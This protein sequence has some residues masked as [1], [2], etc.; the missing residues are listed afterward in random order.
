MAVMFIVFSVHFLF[1]MSAVV[2]TQVVLKDVRQTD[3]EDIK[4]AIVFGMRLDENEANLMYQM[5]DINLNK[6]SDMNSADL[7][8]M[9]CTQ[10]QFIE[11]ELLLKI[12]KK[13]KLMMMSLEEFLS[14]EA[15]INA[16]FEY[17]EPQKR[18]WNEIQNYLNEL[19]A[20]KAL[21]QAI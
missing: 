3:I 14:H 2:N 19:A 15:I 21:D 7:K 11:C 4:K 8:N 17:D 18:V 20:S 6:L 13:I 5:F 16:N 1:A 9:N 12:A 10:I